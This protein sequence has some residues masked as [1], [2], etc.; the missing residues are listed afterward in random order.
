MT[1]MTPL[2][3]SKPLVR[4]AAVGLTVI[5]TSLLAASCSGGGNSPPQ[6]WINATLGPY[7]TGD[8]INTCPEQAPMTPFITAGGGSATSPNPTATGGVV[9]SIACVVEQS[10]GPDSFEVNL[11]VTTAGGT[12]TIDGP[13]N[14]APGAPTVQPNIKASFEGDQSLGETDCTVTFAPKGQGVFSGKIWGMLNCPT[15]VPDGE[16]VDGGMG[17]TICAGSAVFLFQFCNE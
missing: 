15:M 17:T 8:H 14:F 7:S 4:S 13:M 3:S 9:Q 5:A 12:V 2:S 6:V 10:S 16:S 1:S 11:S